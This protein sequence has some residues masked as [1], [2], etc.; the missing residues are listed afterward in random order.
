M[1]R[2]RLAFGVWVGA[3]L[4]GLEGAVLFFSSD[5]HAHLWPVSPVPHPCLLRLPLGWS[6]RL[7]TSRVCLR[8]KSGVLDFFSSR[9][10]ALSLVCHPE[11]IRRGCRSGSQ[12]GNPVLVSLFQII[13]TS[14]LALSRM[15]VLRE[16]VPAVGLTEMQQACGR[17]K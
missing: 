12:S 14:S 2:S 16:Y 17:K 10:C 5:R 8:D 3:A 6:A 7:M 11:T 13:Q 4:L 15:Q 9:S 1:T